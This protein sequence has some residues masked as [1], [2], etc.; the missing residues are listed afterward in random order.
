V[1]RNRDQVIRITESGPSNRYSGIG[2]EL[3][4]LRYRDREIGI[5]VAGPNN[6]ICGIGNEYPE[7]EAYLPE[8]KRFRLMFFIPNCPTHGYCESTC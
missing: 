7:H 1:L 8:I 5:A 2:T 6:R 4:K 3:F